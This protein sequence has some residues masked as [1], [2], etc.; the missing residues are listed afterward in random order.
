MGMGGCHAP[1]A[2]PPEI[3]R[4]PLYKRLGGPQGLSGWVQQISTPQGFDPR[5]VKPVAS[6]Y[7]DWATPAH[8]RNNN[9]NNIKAKEQYIVRHN[10]VCAQLHLNIVCKETGVKLD[11]EH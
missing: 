4:Y 5:T 11:K 10:R 2:L 6:D 7:T 8:K 3:S 9:N 1:A